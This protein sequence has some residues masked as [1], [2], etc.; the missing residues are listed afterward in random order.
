MHSSIGGIGGYLVEHPCG[1]PITDL[2]F[3]PCQ[4]LSRRDKGKQILDEVSDFHLPHMHIGVFSTRKNLHQDSNITDWELAHYAT[5]VT[6]ERLPT[7]QHQQVYSVHA[8][9]SR[10]SLTSVQVPE[11]FEEDM[12]TSSY[13]VLLLLWDTNFCLI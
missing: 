6:I 13:I 4:N 3:L 12:P 10:M 1:F 11:L 8:Q 7:W 2:G 5:S 9:Y